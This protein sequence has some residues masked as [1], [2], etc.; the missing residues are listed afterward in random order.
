MS[1][2]IQLGQSRT[3]STLPLVLATPGPQVPASPRMRRCIALASLSAPGSARS[4]CD[5]SFVFHSAILFWDLY[6]RSRFLGLTAEKC[7]LPETC[8]QS[9]LAWNGVWA[10]TGKPGDTELA[11]RTAVGL[12]TE[13]QN[14]ELWWGMGW[15][16]RVRSLGRDFLCCGNVWKSF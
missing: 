8:V 13:M 12:A 10:G 3:L 16:S 1:P 14:T 6:Y 7:N 5:Q 15:T 11:T 9:L 2:T 4:L